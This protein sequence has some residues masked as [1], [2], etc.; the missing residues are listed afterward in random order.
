M[1]RLKTTN[2]PATFVLGLLVLFMVQF[3]THGETPQIKITPATTFIGGEVKIVLRGFN[4]N[5]LVTV[6]V[7]STNLAGQIWESH[8]EFLT[9]RRGR[10]DLATQAPV[11]GTYRK[12]DASGLF[13]SAS[14]VPGE[15]MTN[16]PARNDP[17]NGPAK[18]DIHFT[19]AVNGEILAT[20]ILPGFLTPPGVEKISV[21]DNGLRGILFLPP[22][23]KP[24]PGAIFLGGSEGGLH[25]TFAA[26]LASKGYAV[27]ALAYFKY[28]DLPKSLENIPLE[29]FGT[30]IDWLA[31]RK[32]V[33]HG[34]I[35]VVGGS[36]GG[37]LALLLGTTYPQIRAVVA[38]APSNVIWPDPEG[39]RQPAWTYQGRPLPFMFM[40]SELSLG[41][42]NE[43]AQLDWKNPMAGTQWC[44]ILLKNKAEVDKA[45]IPV[46]KINGP[47]LLISG[48][49]DHLWPSTE[50]ADM[51][52]ER[53]RQNKHGFPDE[54]LAYPNV[55]HLI[56]LPNM[57]TMN[58][59]LGGDPESTAA[60]AADSWAH[61]VKFLNSAFGDDR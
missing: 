39:K 30:A 49:D 17:A 11:S 8:A 36:R 33:R 4:K 55:G 26:F 37:E 7:A 10:V 50:M 25:D 1:P 24:H 60:A 58:L 13:W 35:A 47:V 31:A 32:E 54:H 56:P 23:K 27:L 5:Q 16:P 20:A 51:V 22:G 34:G 38:V 12:A 29:Y 44:Q 52:M 18:V 15:K 9:D 59:P 61:M 57:S 42:S 28:D 45:S 53:L 21:H 40:N 41:E 43:M 2:T 46:E 19:A 14:E 48:N 3:A 6:S